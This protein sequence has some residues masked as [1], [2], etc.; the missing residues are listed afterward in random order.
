[1]TMTWEPHH[2]EF[3]HAHNLGVL[4]TGRAD[5][6]PQ[7]SMVLYG[8]DAEDRLLISAKDYTAKWHNAVRQPKVSLTVV[9]GR[10]HLVIYGRAETIAHDPE[11]AAITAAIFALMSGN[12]VDPASLVPMLDEQRRTVIRITPERTFHQE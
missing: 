3:L 4:A 6:S 1:M 7:Q 10:E 2:L 9:D 8:L 5:G 11:R 12:D